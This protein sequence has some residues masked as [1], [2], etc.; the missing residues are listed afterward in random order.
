[1]ARVVVVADR[2][3]VELERLGVVLVGRGEPRGAPARLAVA[4]VGELAV[5]L[6]RLG[7]VLP[8]RRCPSRTSARGSARPAEALRGG[9]LVPLDRLVV[10][11]LALELRG[12]VELRAR[13]AR[14][15][16]LGDGCARRSAWPRSASASRPSAPSLPGCPWRRRC[17][18]GGA[19]RSRGSRRARRRR[20]PPCGTR[21][22]PS[23]SSF[24]TPRPRWLITP[25]R[26]ID[27]VE[28]AAA[29]AAASRRA[30]AKRP[31]CA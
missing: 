2:A 20:P 22:A 5:A 23:A 19:R 24:G 31:V 29:P 30:S 11:L 15:R 6:A 17:R 27:A 14:R 8:S 21:R 12:E 18:S 13:V 26:I 3:V 16:P 1:M 9:A 28:P 4:G 7:A 25:S 10:F